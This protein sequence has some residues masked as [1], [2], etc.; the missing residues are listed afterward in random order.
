MVGGI[1]L[2]I[3]A[4]VLIMSLFKQIMYLT[5]RCESL[6]PFDAV[7]LLDDRKNLSNI[8]S[9]CFTE[10]FE[11]DSMK[12]YIHSKT[13]NLHK[14]RSKL[15]KKFGLWWFQEMDEAE[16][17]AKKDEVIVLKEGIH[18]EAALSD[19]M[20]QLANIREPFDNV[21]YKFFLIPD[22]QPGKSV[23][24]LKGHHSFTDGLGYG[25]F[26]LMLS[27]N[28]DSSALPALKPVSFGKQLCIWILLPFLFIKS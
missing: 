10:T 16:W 12:K 28:Y 21:Q 17:L 5:C 7:F 27:G 22:Y 15:S 25:A 14:C 18:D 26:L 9:C 11:F 24:I 6:G 20:C 13:S 8:V 3:L 19:Y 23:A 1:A 4:Y 2:G